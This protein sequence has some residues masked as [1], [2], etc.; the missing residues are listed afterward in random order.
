MLQEFHYASPTTLLELV[1]VYASNFYGSSLL[2]LKSK[3]VEGIYTS[4]NMMIRNIFKLDRTTHRSLIA[5]LLGRKHLKVMLLSRY[6][7]FHKESFL[8][9]KIM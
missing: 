6:V 4:W 3:S 1:C 7:K 9:F 8:K 2:D 5:P